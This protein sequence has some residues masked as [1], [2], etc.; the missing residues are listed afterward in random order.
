MAF[1]LATLDLAP[2]GAWGLP[3]RNGAAARVD[4][5]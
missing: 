4:A 1:S 3:G 5:G 2:M